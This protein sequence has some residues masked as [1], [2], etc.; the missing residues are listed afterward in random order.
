MPGLP[1]GDGQQKYNSLR[2]EQHPGAW[3]SVVPSCSQ[4]SQ[5]FH[6]APGPEVPPRPPTPAPGLYLPSKTRELYKAVRR[7]RG[8]WILRAWRISVCRDSS[9]VD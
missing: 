5:M 6:T 1:C 4:V 9:G 7:W 8:R 3:G 2:S